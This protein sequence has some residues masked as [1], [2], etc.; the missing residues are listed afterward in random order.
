MSDGLIS[1]LRLGVWDRIKHFSWTCNDDSSSTA[2]FKGIKAKKRLE[3]T[4]PKQNYLNMNEV[5]FFHGRE[6]AQTFIDDLDL[7]GIFRS[8]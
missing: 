5:V 8:S 7:N 3:I 4:A 1:K 6:Q 2:L